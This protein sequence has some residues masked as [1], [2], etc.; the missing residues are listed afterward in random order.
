MHDLSISK[1]LPFAIV[2]CECSDTKAK[3]RICS[4]LKSGEDP[5]EANFGVRNLQRQRL[6]KLSIFEESIT[7]KYTEDTSIKE[8]IYQLNLLIDPNKNL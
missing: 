5:S 8:C 4:R 6:E 7:V 3:D 1:N 2:A